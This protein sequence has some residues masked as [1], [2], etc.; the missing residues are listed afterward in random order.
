MSLLKI[1]F[2]ECCTLRGGL[3]VSDADIKEALSS[4]TPRRMHC[5]M[6]GPKL[7]PM[8]LL[9]VLDEYLAILNDYFN[10]LY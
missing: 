8:A 10:L 5:R 9:W 3:L 4:A 7:H 1:Q 2:S 6:V